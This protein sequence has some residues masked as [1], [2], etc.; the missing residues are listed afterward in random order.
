MQSF[1]KYVEKKREKLS[2]YYLFYWTTLLPLLMLFISLCGYELLSSAISFQP[3]EFPLVFFIRQII[4][5]LE[6]L[7]FTFIFEI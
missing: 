7:Y 6:C 2:L 3:E 4:F 1:F 5:I